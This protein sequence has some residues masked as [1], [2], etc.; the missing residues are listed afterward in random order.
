MLQTVPIH[1]DCVVVEVMTV[2]TREK[3][4]FDHPTFASVWFWPSNFKTGY[5]DHPTL[6]IVHN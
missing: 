4:I 6:K 2:Y 5:L 1:E 3:S